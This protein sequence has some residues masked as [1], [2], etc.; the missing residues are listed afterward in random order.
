[1]KI[2]VVDKKD[3]KILYKAEALFGLDN[4]IIQSAYGIDPYKLEMY[5]IQRSKL[6][7]TYEIDDIVLEKLALK[8]RKYLFG[9]MS[10]ACMLY[11]MLTNFEKDT[12]NIAVY[13]EETEVVSMIAYDNKYSNIYLWEKYQCC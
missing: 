6:E 9:R 2:L 7:N 12:D 10:E 8:K 3:N 4:V 13:P 1:M 5:L 11:A